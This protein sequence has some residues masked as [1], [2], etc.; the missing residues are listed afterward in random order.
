MFYSQDSIA[1][2]E[3]D[4]QGQG[5]QDRGEKGQIIKVSKDKDGIVTREVLTKNW[6]DWIDYWS[7][8]FDFESK[9]EII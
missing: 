6:T 5:Q 9:R 3:A 8:D 7:V 2:A 4:N 1:N